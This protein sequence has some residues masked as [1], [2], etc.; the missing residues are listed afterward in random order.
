MRLLLDQNLSRRVAALLREAGHD[1]AH[2]AERGLATAHDDAVF[3]LAAAE[4]RVLISED[5]DFGAL[6]ARSAARTPSFVL[7]RTVEPLRP[8]DQ[9]ALLLANLPHAARE[10]EEGAIVVLGRGRMRV[11]PLPI[12]PPD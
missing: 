4:D 5:T 1:A 10:L 12:A 6:L 7:L 11:R 3:A 2:V 8:D 9:A